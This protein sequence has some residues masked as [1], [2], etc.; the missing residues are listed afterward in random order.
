MGT[1]RDRL[2]ET[3][4]LTGWMALWLQ[5]SGCAALYSTVCYNVLEYKGRF[6]F[7]NQGH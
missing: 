2:T 5:A 1:D 6:H 3:H 7:C 4:M